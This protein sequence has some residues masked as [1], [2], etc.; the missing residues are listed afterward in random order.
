MQP[1]AAMTP[2]LNVALDNGTVRAVLTQR[3]AAEI[4]SRGISI[5]DGAKISVMIVSD[6]P[7]L[8]GVGD[9]Q[10]TYHA[11]VSFEFDKLASNP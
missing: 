3:A 2:V 9:E 1:V 11:Y 10:E 5:P 7:M 8:G 4:K 6:R